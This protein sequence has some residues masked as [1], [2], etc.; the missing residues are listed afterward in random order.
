[1]YDDDYYTPNGYNGNGPCGKWRP[2]DADLMTFDLIREFKLDQHEYNYQYGVIT[3]IQG[4]NIVQTAYRLEEETNLTMRVVEAFP[5]G[6]TKFL[7]N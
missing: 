4:S 2:G 6:K 1:M 3:E 7:Y 5:R